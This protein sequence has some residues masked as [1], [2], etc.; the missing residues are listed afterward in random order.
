MFP[1]L[2]AVEHEP[3]CVYRQEQCQYCKQTLQFLFLEVFYRFIDYGEIFHYFPMTSTVTYL[4]IPKNKL[5]ATVI[6]KFHIN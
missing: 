5:N 4:T 1:K 6:I 2:F 3:Q